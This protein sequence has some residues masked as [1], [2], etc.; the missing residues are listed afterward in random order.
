VGKETLDTAGT[1]ITPIGAL[2]DR[3]P[4]RVGLSFLR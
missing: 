3:G 4:D 1:R 2:R